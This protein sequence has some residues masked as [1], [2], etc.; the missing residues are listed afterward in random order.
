MSLD[1]LSPHA[2]GCVLRLRV[3]PGARKTSPEGI[4]EGRLRLR[5]Q[6]PP[7]EGKAN[8]AAAA[9]AA[10]TFGI[11]PSA[12]TILRGDHSRQKDLLLSGVTVDQ[13]EG[14]LEMRSKG[15]G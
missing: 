13:A 6:A 2:D 5:V 7:V 1:C 8:Q 3:T 15:E 12:V 14:K 11:R 9:W 10:K 4:L